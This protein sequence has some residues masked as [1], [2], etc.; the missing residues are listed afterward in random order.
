MTKPTTTP[1]Q[2]F[3]WLLINLTTTMAELQPQPFHQMVTNRGL[4]STIEGK[5]ELLENPLRASGWAWQEDARLKSAL[6]AARL[7]YQLGTKQISIT[8]CLARRFL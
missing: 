7:R 2:L 3:Q 4:C 6:P 5:G 1:L 8:S